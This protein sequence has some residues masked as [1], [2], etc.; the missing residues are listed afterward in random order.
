MHK[1]LLVGLSVFFL[2]FLWHPIMLSSFPVL[3]LGASLA[4][5]ADT[6]TV[7]VSETQCSASAP[8]SSSPVVTVRNRSYSGIYNPTYN[9]DFFLGIP[10]AQVSLQL[11]ARD[12][13]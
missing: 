12:H 11:N 10:Y 9:Q 3:S 2:V 7:T 1:Y 13:Y 8:T 5:A 4:I 6:V